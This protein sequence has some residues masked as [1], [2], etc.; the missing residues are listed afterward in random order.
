LDKNAA[1]LRLTGRA[2]KRTARRSDAIDKA[3]GI[4]DDATGRPEFYSAAVTV[5][6]RWHPRRSA[7]RY[8][9][10]HR[11]EFGGD[12]GSAQ[13]AEFLAV[14][15]HR[16][17]RGFAGAGQ[18]D[19]DIGMPGFAGAV[20]DAARDRDVERFDAG[21]RLQPMNGTPRRILPSAVRRCRTACRRE[22][23]V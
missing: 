7:G 15:E 14:D 20:D 23:A 19:A 10:H 5:L 22:C 1:L 18:G 16:R 4:S 6:G 13:G 11:P 9:D 17:R 12:V 21:L 2:R 3:I 8:S